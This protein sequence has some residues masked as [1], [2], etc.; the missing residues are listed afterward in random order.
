MDCTHTADES[1]NPLRLALLYCPACGTLVTFPVQAACDPRL[2]ARL[3]QLDIA[4]EALH[5]VKA[6]L[7]EELP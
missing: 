2:S 7:E 1:Q 5:H 3:D 4:L 6:S